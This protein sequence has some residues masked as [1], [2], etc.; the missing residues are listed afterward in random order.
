MENIIKDSNVPLKY[1][2]KKPRKLTNAGHLDQ[3]ISVIMMQDVWVRA[4]IHECCILYGMPC[5]ANICIS[6]TDRFQYAFGLMSVS[7][8]MRRLPDVWK[9]MY[10]K[11]EP[12]E[13]A[14]EFS[15]RFYEK[16]NKM[17]IPTSSEELE[18]ASKIIPTL[19]KKK[20]VKE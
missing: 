2:K 1:T 12:K 4:F 18:M 16:F 6:K 7:T 13:A 15:R 17:I 3:P 20:S 10:A 19:M 11:V 14:W 5:V 9:G 8:S